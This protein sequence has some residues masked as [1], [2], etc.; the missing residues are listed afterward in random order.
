MQV[1]GAEPHQPESALAMRYVLL[2]GKRYLWRDILKIRREQVKQ[3][4]QTRQ[5]ISFV[6][7]NDARPVSQRSADGRYS[8]PTLFNPA[9]QR[10]LFSCDQYIY[11]C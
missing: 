6:M 10:D 9:K 3:E 8:E 1:I 7:H 4:R 5:P 11:I 2:D